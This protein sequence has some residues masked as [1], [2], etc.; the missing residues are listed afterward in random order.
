MVDFNEIIDIDTSLKNRWE[1]GT[2][3]NVEYILSIID[4]MGT[5]KWTQIHDGPNVTVSIAERGSQQSMTN[6][7]MRSVC[8]FPRSYSYNAI[9]NMINNKDKFSDRVVKS[10]VL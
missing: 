9:H 3:F 6:P 1:V 8:V 10:E 2:E 5:T 4:T 7:V